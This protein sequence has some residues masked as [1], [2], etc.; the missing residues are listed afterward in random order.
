MRA[1]TSAVFLG[2]L[3]MS[4]VTVKTPGL[5]LVRLKKYKSKFGKRYMHLRIPHN[6]QT[7]FHYFQIER[8]CKSITMKVK[9]QKRKRNCLE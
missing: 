4:F 2:P 3:K 1:V 8:G 7:V 5:I 6:T 9:K